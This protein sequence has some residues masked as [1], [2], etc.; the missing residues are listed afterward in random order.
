MRQHAD[1]VSQVRRAEE[2]WLAAEESL[3]LASAA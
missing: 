3:N 1:M 2:I